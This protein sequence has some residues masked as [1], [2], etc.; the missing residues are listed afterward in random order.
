[1]RPNGGAVNRRLLVVDDDRA[2]VGML[3]I[4]LAREGWEVIEATSFVQAQTA[5]GPFALVLADVQLPNGDGRHLREAYPATPF[6]VMSGHPE[7]QPDLA[8][9]FTLAQLRE[10]VQKAVDGL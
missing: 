5:A 10:A 2:I 9:P 8:K 7:H 1:M 4:A 6:V 3:G